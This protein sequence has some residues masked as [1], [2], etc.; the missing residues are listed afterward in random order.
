MTQDFKYEI[1]RSIGTIASFRIN[2]KVRHKELNVIS[3]NGRDPKVDIREWNDDH[4]QMSKGITLTR[5]E[6]RNLYKL[7]QE[8]IGSDT[9]NTE[10]S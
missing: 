2:G 5:N 10:A 6:A 3:W 8:Y 9:E 4:T 1:V 7:L